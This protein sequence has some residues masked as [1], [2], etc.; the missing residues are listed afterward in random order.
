MTWVIKI[1][2]EHDDSWKPPASIQVV[3]TDEMVDLVND[4]GFD[5]RVEYFKRLLA[6]IDKEL[7]NEK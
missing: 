6:E 1:I 7:K 2:Y 3:L 5:V 4:S